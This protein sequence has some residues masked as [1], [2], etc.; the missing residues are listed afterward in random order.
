[1][2]IQEAEFS[3]TMGLQWKLWEEIER[4][5]AQGDAINAK[6][7]Q[8][9]AQRK[10]ADHEIKQLQREISH[11]SAELQKLRRYK[12]HRNQPNMQ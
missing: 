10:D 6:K 7:R 9:Q 2:E 11:S 12:M 4:I 8:I 3:S 1:M 5:R